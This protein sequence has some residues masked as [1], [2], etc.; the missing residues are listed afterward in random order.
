MV[1]HP[2]PA[3]DRVTVPQAARLRGRLAMPP[4]K[5]ITHRALLL[6]GVATGVSR[7][8]HASDALDPRSS[9]ACLRALGV[10]VE[11][12][13]GPAAEPADEEGGGT[14]V[15][16][17]VRSPGWLGWRA[18]EGALDCANSGTT[19]RLLAGLLAGVP[20]TATLDGDES[21][22]R[23]PMARVVEPLRAMGAIL[24][25]A[26][27]DTRPPLNVTGRR[28]LSPL[29]WVTSVPSAQVKSAV[30]LAGLAG[31][32][33]T[34]VEEATA[35]RDHTERM[36]RARGVPVETLTHPSD[37][38]GERTRV[39]V[40]GGRLPTPL[41]ERVPGDISA[42]AFWLVAAAAHPDAELSLTDVGINPTRRA[43]IDLLRAM[44][45]DI[46][47][48]PRAGAR[49]DADDVGEPSADLLVRSSRLQGIEIG[50]AEVA[51]AIDEIPALCLAAACARGRTQ[52]RGAGELRHKE[53]DRLVGIVE[54]LR[55][56]G[57][58]V[59]L[60][61]DDVMIDGGAN[62]PA[63]GL[64]GAATHSLADHRLAMTFAIAG[65]LATGATTLDGVNAAAVSYPGFF[66][67]LERVRA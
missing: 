11:Q 29:T 35:T 39:S 34:T 57:A 65:L 52:I 44:G 31:D 51:R 15:D 54:G 28:P 36:L 49:E 62:R 14:S 22:R 32:G 67:D 4:D 18:P 43:I 27:G 38:P 20:L 12:V 64:H 55:A 19:L 45:A 5:S 46:Q 37:R 21:L 16:W 23:R 13:A 26:A 33:V 17:L 8:S 47:E 42:A 48:V 1:L 59:A 66:T 63:F 25:G 50:P 41:D 7:I 60:V 10:E 58:A 9:A 53:S 56:L 40:A 3:S 6:A 2:P 61:G 30:L 24:K